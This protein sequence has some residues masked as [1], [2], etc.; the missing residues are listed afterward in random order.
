[1]RSSRLWSTLVVALSIAVGLAPASQSLAW[2][3]AA[4]ASTQ[5]RRE[6]L[7]QR[8]ANEEATCQKWMRAALD[9]AIFTISDAQV[10]ETWSEAKVTQLKRNSQCKPF[11]ELRAKCESYI[12]KVGQ[13]VG[14]GDGKP[15]SVIGE[16]IDARERIPGCKSIMGLVIPCG[17][18]EMAADDL[19]RQRPSAEVRAFLQTCVNQTVVSGSR[20]LVRA[21]L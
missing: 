14:G 18:V 5:L 19:R 3:S 2:T 11:F 10:L 4:G 17:L 6:L 13:A 15:A 8:V 12:D 16:M 21:V 7:W 9:G 1:M 20:G